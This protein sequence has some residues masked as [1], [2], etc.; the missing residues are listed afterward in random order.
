MLAFK[1]IL[2]SL[3]FVTAVPALAA[4]ADPA[5]AT[6][7]YHPDVPGQ[8]ATTLGTATYAKI[9][10]SAIFVSGRQPDEAQKN[11]AWFLQS[12]PDQKEPVVVNVDRAT[13][14]VRAT[15]KGVTRLAAYYGDQGCIIHAEGQDGIFFKPTPVKSALPEA[16]KTP[17][18]M[19][20]APS[21]KP[22]PKGLD[23]AKVDAAVAKA[24]ADPAALTIAVVVLYQGEIVG[25][26]YD[27]GTTK[28]TQNES[29]SMGKSEMATL[30]GVAMH[31]GAFKLD[32]PAPVPDWRRPGDPRGAIRVR[33]ILNM[34]SGL[35]FSHT[36]TKGYD[37]AVD[38]SDHFFVHAGAVDAYKYAVA[39]PVEF[40]PQTVGRYRNVDPMS[41]G[42]L[43]RQFAESKGEEW[44]T[45]PQRHLFDKIGIRRQVMETDPYGNFLMSTFDYGTARNWARLG[46]LYLQDGMWNGQRLLPEGYAKFVSTLAPAWPR[47]EYGGQFW[48]NGEGRWKALPREAYYM[49]GAGGQS[50]IIVPSHELVVVRMGHQR[51]SSLSGAALNAALSDLVPLIEAAK[52]SG[53]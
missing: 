27:L 34:S 5:P 44:L 36:S 38:Y 48:V 49:S 52:K 40:P 25:E 33:D 8:S 14:R 43:V 53:G 32:D 21:G 13:K 31:E 10:C 18:P 29:W 37:P 26:R 42:F 16:Q 15:V 19:G 1:R 7:A 6:R 30:V 47:K 9:L 20:D 17:W 35:A 22:Y 23:K 39:S 4:A 3:V 51:G 46:Q 2:T 24:F 28:D 12:E 45:W 50:T 41:L 11:S